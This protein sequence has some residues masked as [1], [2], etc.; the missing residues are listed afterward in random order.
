MIG[1]DATELDAELGIEMGSRVVGVPLLVVAEAGRGLRMGTMMDGWESR[2][3]ISEG[4]T[5]RRLDEDG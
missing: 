3:W 1:E 2:S 4:E 5:A